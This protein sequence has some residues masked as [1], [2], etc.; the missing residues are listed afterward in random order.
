MM[1]SVLAHLTPLEI[2]PWTAET[3][4]STHTLEYS[5][6]WSK[7]FSSYA[8]QADLC[9][10]FDRLSS[11]DEQTLQ[12]AATAMAG[13]DYLLTCIRELLFESVREQEALHM[14]SRRNCI[15]CFPGEAD[16]SKASDRMGF[17]TEGKTL[18]KIQTFEDSQVFFAD[19][20]LLNTSQI[21]GDILE[22]AHLYWK[23]L[24]SSTRPDNVEVLLQGSF[25]ILSATASSESP[26]IR[27]S[28]KTF[29]DVFFDSYSSRS[30]IKEA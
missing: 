18:L 27:M 8:Y 22:K 1:S 16:I 2:G 17:S 6:Y 5:L 14:P 9:R 21:V 15:F 30:G 10:A 4:F 25:K 13:R 3:I 28:G 23:G 12:L 19:S 7:T 26:L 29:H 20:S 24:S 11:C